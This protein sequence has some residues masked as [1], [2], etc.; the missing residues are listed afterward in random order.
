MSSTLSQPES[1]ERTRNVLRVRVFGEP[2]QLAAVEPAVRAACAT[3]APIWRPP[4]ELDFRYFRPRPELH[5]HVLVLG[6]HTEGPQQRPIQVAGC[7]VDPRAAAVSCVGELVERHVGRV[8]TNPRPHRDSFERLDPATAFPVGEHIGAPVFAHR[9]PYP[10]FTADRPLTWAPGRRY[11]DGEPIWVPESLVGTDAPETAERL[12]EVTTIGLAAGAG[13]R[14]AAAHGLYEMLERS[15][16]M[17]YWQTHR[18]FELL[19]GAAVADRAEFLAEDLRLGWRTQLLQ[20]RTPVGTGVAIALTRHTETLAFGVGMSA[21]PDPSERLGHA[22]AEAVQIRLLA[23][24]HRGRSTDSLNSFEDHILYYCHPD[25]FPQLDTLVGAPT[26]ELVARPGDAETALVARLT[27]AGSQVVAI[28]LTPGGA[29][30]PAVVRV[31]ATRLAQMEV[32]ERCACRPEPGLIGADLPGAY[33]P[34]PYP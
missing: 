1:A 21:H 6:E 33:R 23:S 19:A 2:G 5:G 14:Q 32:R 29:Q 7:A 17:H 18:P 3:W 13:Y 16:I 15:T 11:P 24:L 27:A 25:R 34:H 8:W 30:R 12:R 9:W 20:A 31:L 10:P 4:P 26:E 22:I 28:E